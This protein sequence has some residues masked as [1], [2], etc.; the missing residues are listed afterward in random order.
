LNP[1]ENDPNARPTYG[2]TDFSRPRI[3]VAASNA[4]LSQVFSWMFAGLLLTGL[5]GWYVAHSDFAHAVLGG[6][7]FLILVIAQL[8]LVFYLSA[9]INHLQPGTATALYLGYSALSGVTFSVIFLAYSLGNI[10]NVLLMTGALF[11]VLAVFGKTTKMDLTKI[12]TICIAALIAIIIAMV[13]NIFIGSSVATTVISVL[14]VIIFAGLTAWDMQRLTHYSVQAYGN[15]AA[16]DSRMAILGAL[17]LYLDFIN[18][19][20]F[21]LRLFGGGRR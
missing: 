5:V 4:F 11:A 9:R 18:M 21:L 17:A 19:F 10:L 13:V 6:G 12:G 8:G 3:G 15:D 16:M 14:G 7:S 20:L 1:Y 2:A